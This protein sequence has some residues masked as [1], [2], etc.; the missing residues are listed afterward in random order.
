MK[1]KITLAD[2][3]RARR[4]QLK[5]I[6]KLGG[7]EESIQRAIKKAVYESFSSWKETN[8]PKFDENQFCEKMELFLKPLFD[9]LESKDINT[10]QLFGTDDMNKSVLLA[11]LDVADTNTITPRRFAINGLQYA[12]QHIADGDDRIKL[13]NKCFI[14]IT[15]ASKNFTAYLLSNRQP[16]NPDYLRV[17]N[18]LDIKIRIYKNKVLITYQQILENLDELVDFFS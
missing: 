14:A 13:L 12:K 7:V 18:D 2:V 5:N 10:I 8:V 15:P 16:A 17:T 4:M 3:Q 1:R 11:N 9:L 6:D